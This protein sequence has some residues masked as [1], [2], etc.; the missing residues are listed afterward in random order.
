M[1][2]TIGTGPF[3][4][5]PGGSFNFEASGPE[6][7][8]YF[9]DS[10]RRV[11]GVLAGETV[12]D[13]RHPKLLHETGHLPIYYFP[14]EE[15]RMDLLEPTD[16]STHCPF[17]GD[18][19]YWSVRVGD[20]LVENAVW[21]Y[22]HPLPE[23]P[24]ISEHVAFYFRM[25]D[26][27]WEEDERI[28]VHPRD[29]YHRVD[30]LPSSRHVRISLEGEPLAESAR[31]L[32]LFETGLPPRYYLPR[33]DVRA[34]VLEPSDKRT[35]CP[36]KGEAGYWSVRTAGID[37]EDLVWCYADPLR[38]VEDIAGRLC[39]FDERVDMEVDGERSARPVTQWSPARA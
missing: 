9:E 4:R 13:S 30:V 26:E 33:E 22:P 29:P 23:A 19:V 34:D 18:A 37:E 8:L 3:G 6:H 11:R 39:F 5:T 14:R 24:P 17:K 10:P 38:A 32:V 15:V 1:T 27:W 12:V 2:L 7:V 35:R 16:H 28:H 36:Y 20:R 21:G 31:P 25:L